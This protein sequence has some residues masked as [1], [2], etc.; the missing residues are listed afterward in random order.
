MSVIAVVGATVVYVSSRV[1]NHPMRSKSSASTSLLGLRTVP[2]TVYG[3]KLTGGDGMRNPKNR[4]VKATLRWMTVRY[5]T[6]YGR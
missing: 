6:E 5:G 4:T 3:R 2:Y 1:K